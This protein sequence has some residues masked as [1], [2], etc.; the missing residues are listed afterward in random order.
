MVKGSLSMPARLLG[1]LGKGRR[2]ECVQLCTSVITDGGG[3]AAGVSA[4]MGHTHMEAFRVY[5]KADLPTV[6][7]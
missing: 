3:E 5:L 4:P 1:Y 7:S 6:I 2:G